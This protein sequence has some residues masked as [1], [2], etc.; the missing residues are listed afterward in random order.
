[1]KHPT[2]FC[3]FGVN[4]TEMKEYF[5]EIRTFGGVPTV[6]EVEKRLLWVPGY[7]AVAKL[8]VKKWNENNAVKISG[9]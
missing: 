7:K 5:A 1:M 4:D 9:R 3:R 6:D 2:D 8:L